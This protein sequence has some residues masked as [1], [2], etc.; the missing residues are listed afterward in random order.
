MPNLPIPGSIIRPLASVPSISS[1]N[2]ATTSDATG[3]F[4]IN[5]LVPGT[6]EIIP[7]FPGINFN[8]PAFSITI[9]D[10][11]VALNFDASGDLINELQTQSSLPLNLICPINHGPI[12]PGTFTIEGYIK[13]S[14]LT[15]PYT[16]VITIIN[17]ETIAE[18]YRNS[19]GFGL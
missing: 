11:N 8:P 19:L 5:N 7:M 16:E 12:T 13:L 14:P 4:E 9:T 6:Y 1:N 10:S 2:M 3:Y 17:D 15:K 18:N